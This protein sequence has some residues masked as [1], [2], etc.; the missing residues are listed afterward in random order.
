MNKL[1]MCTWKKIVCE[2]RGGMCLTKLS[3][4]REV[5]CGGHHGDEDD[6]TTWNVMSEVVAL[7]P[8]G[9]QRGGGR[10]I[11]VVTNF[12][13]HWYLRRTPHIIP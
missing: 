11:F 8:L 12:P 5:T 13:R 6:A 10:V 2:G 7:R 4:F 1:Q 9:S 3:R